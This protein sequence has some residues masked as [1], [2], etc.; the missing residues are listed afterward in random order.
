MNIALT[1]VGE[2]VN[3]VCGLFKITRCPPNNLVSCSRYTRIV[4]NCPLETD[5]GISSTG[6]Q[7]GQS[8][9]KGDQ[10][11]G[12]LLPIFRTLMRLA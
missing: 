7:S 12:Q 8:V 5:F 2:V 10:G 3:H 9:L 4:R 1:L 6:G 11:F